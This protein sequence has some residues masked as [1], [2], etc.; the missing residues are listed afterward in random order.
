MRKIT[1]TMCLMLACAFISS[2][3][4]RANAQAFE[5]DKSYISVGYGYELFSIKRIFEYYEDEADFDITGYGPVLLKYEYGLSDKVGVGLALGY[6]GANVSWTGEK[7]ESVNGE[8]VNRTYKYEYKQSK[9]TTVARLNWHLGDHD[10]IDPYIGL[11]LGFKTNRFKLSSDD[12]NFDDSEIKFGGLF[13]MSM[14]AS[15]G[16]RFYFT[17]NIGAFIELGMGHGFAQGGLQMKF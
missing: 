9:L 12:K 1:I 3:F 6:G 15:F 11:G 2:T 7:T 5:A 17:D 13:P 10:K 8:V 14:S 16:C 4:N